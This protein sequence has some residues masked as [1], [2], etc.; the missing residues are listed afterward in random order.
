MPAFSEMPVPMLHEVRR[1]TMV[2]RSQCLIGL[3]IHILTDGS[4]RPAIDNRTISK[5]RAT[6]NRG[7]LRECEG[8]CQ[9]DRARENDCF[10][11]HYSVPPV[12]R[13]RTK[14]I[15]FGC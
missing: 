1:L 8:T 6:A 7:G 10:E 15:G 4:N 9:S 14:T 5:V 13:K 3:K 12:V 11:F 2:L